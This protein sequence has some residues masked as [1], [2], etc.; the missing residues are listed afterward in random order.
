MISPLDAGAEVLIKRGDTLDLNQC[1][2]IAL[3]KQPNI[4]AA[5]GNVNINQSRV[6]QAKSTYYPQ[7]NW[8]SGYSR[9]SPATGVLLKGGSAYDEYLSNVNLSQTIYD[10]E[11]TSTQVKIQ[12][13]NLDSSRSDLDNV[14]SQIVFGVKQAYFGL[15]QAKRN[16]DVAAE[17]VQQFQQHL[18]RAK[19]FFEVGTKPKFDVTKAE[20]D[21]SNAKLNLIKGEN[22]FRIAR[23]SLNNAIGM[24][25]APGY[26]IVD[27][28]GFQLYTTSLED[29][30]KRAYT[31]RP[32][33]L[34][35]SAKR[36]AAERTIELQKKG[37]YPTLSGNANYAF[38]GEEFPLEKGWTVGA[39]LNFPLFSGLSTKYQ[40]EEARAN[41]QVLKANEEALKQSIHLDVEQAYLNLQQARDSIT[42]TELTVRQATE[43]FE[44]ANGRYTSGVGSPIEITDALVSLANAKTA[45]IAALYDY[46]VARASMEKAMGIK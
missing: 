5:M 15:L 6:G 13:L 42:T 29:A 10:F 38:S 34:S 36:E 26:T 2:E 31:F 17:T 37:Y 9:I 40:V 30:L 1:I 3:K 24:P 25:E 22:A 43:N 35:L 8:T 44:L 11:K 16:R 7:I 27:E 46:K 19:G 20:V 39:T 23:V 45:Y 4:V 21:L 12:N 41:L 28:F 18:D 32:D 14:A 33:L